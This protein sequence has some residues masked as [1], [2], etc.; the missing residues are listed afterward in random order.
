M[1]LRFI[2]LIWILCSF[3]ANMN[4][5]ITESISYFPV[6]A[7]TGMPESVQ[8]SLTTKMNRIITENGYGSIDKADRF[9]MLAKYDL[10]EKDVAPTTPP[11]IAQT[12]A[13]T[14]ILGDAVENKTYASASF[15]LKG[16]GINEVK[17]WQTAMNRL[18]PDN[19][20]IQQMFGEAFKKI[21]S[22]YAANCQNIISEA[23]ALAGM[24]KYEQAIYN[25]MS[26]PDVCTDCRQEAQ[27]E[28][29]SIYGKMTETEY[30]DLLA[31]AKHAWAVSPDAD[32]AQRA[33]EYINSISADSN[34]FA[35]AEEF[36]GTIYKKL[37]SDKERAWQQK[38]KE[39]ND[40]LQMRK[41][42]AN[43][44]HREKMAEIAAARSVAEKWAENQP[45]TKVYLNW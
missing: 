36:V 27:A 10:V 5:G 2:L 32:G 38:I 28:A 22:Y 44:H 23:R 45:Q 20:K 13:V 40:N 37:S 26:V 17:A 18:Q 35:S 12:V 11:R 7:G 8:L 4:A 1:K 3:I 14:F 33:M 9:I 34:V 31:K 16:I 15:E 24:G 29:V 21:E 6:V 19:P 30:A 25:L 39:Y 43:R 41:A 42:Q